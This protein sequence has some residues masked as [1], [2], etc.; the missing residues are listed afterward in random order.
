MTEAST[1]RTLEVTQLNFL[2]EPEFDTI[3]DDSPPETNTVLLAIKRNMFRHQL[4]QQ[5]S[6]KGYK[7]V[8][9]DDAQ[10]ALLKLCSVDPSRTVLVLEEEIPSMKEK[11]VAKMDGYDVLKHAPRIIS[12]FEKMG[13]FFCRSGLSRMLDLIGATYSFR[14]R[15]LQERLCRRF[16]RLWDLKQIETRIVRESGAASSE[17]LGNFVFPV[18]SDL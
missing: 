9:A 4:Y 11:E 3:T 1:E 12:D 15:L 10:D 7:V 13:L 6:N 8:T 5:L 2:P 18:R 17:S 14:N 16:P